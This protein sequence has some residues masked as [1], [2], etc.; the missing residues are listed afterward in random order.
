M[1][2]VYM[3]NECGCFKKSEFEKE[4]SFDT[5]REAYQYSNALAEHMNEDFCGKHLFVSEKMD[6]NVF[7]IRVGDNPNFG[8]CGTGGESSCSSGSCGC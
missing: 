2:T 6:G 5:Q 8:S 1:Y 3:E 7:M 4:K